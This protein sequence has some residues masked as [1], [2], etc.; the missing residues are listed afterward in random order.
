MSQMMQPK[1]EIHASRSD[2]RE[3]IGRVARNTGVFNTEELGTVF[4]LFDAY[5]EKPSSGYEFLSATVDGRLAGFACFGPTAL[6]EGAYDY[7]WLAT[8]PA[9]QKKGVG[10]ALCDAVE[11]EVAKRNGRLIVI[12]TSGMGDYAPAT[13]LY[14]RI[15]YVLE[16][17]I[18]DFYKP[19]D[20]LLVYVKYL[21]NEIGTDA[22]II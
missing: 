20:D 21:S 15:G 2:E 18:R 19:G 7:Y 6:T 13:R 22:L 16:G 17:R 1:L 8:D 10:R 5:T 14:E 3:E 4:E 11:A 9:M 12:W